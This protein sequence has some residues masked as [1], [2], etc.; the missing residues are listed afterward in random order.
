LPQN[1]GLSVL[2]SIGKTDK[3]M[4]SGAKVIL[5][6]VKKNPWWKK[7]CETVRCCDA[8]AISFVAK[9]GEEVFAHF[10]KVAVK[11]QS[12]MRN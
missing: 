8:S 6:L 4:V 7:K 11:R 3:S 10:R 12:N 5:F 9:V 1:G 2:S